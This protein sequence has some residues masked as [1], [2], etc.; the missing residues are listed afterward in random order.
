M[1]YGLPY[2]GNKSKIAKDVTEFARSLGK[3]KIID[4]F[5]GGGA[6]TD[7]ATQEGLDAHYNDLD[8]GITGLVRLCM[9]G[10]VPP[11]PSPLTNAAAH[12]GEGGAIGAAW[13]IVGSFMHKGSGFFPDKRRAAVNAATRMGAAERPGSATFSSK[14]FAAVPTGG[15][16]VFADPPYRG[17]EDMYVRNK[18]E[19]DF[20]R[21]DKWLAG[22]QQPCLLTANWVPKGWKVIKR[23]GNKNTTFAGAGR[24][25]NPDHELESD[26]RPVAK[27][28]GATRQMARLE[29]LPS[30]GAP[31]S[32]PPILPPSDHKLSRGKQAR[33]APELPLLPPP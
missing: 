5:G 29:I 20:E 4:V 3:N 25:D 30:R 16:L 26:R 10:Q 31:S 17:S 27:M 7:C 18:G 19:F 14:D 12:A 6:V 11:Q 21:L 32:L 23:W 24:S 28:R 1:S 8:S 9:R 2:L 15:G 13:R 33:T 22:L